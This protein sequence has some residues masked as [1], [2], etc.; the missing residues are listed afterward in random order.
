MRDDPLRIGAGQLFWLL[1]KNAPVR[2]LR[3]LQEI[4]TELRVLAVHDCGVEVHSHLAV[5][6]LSRCGFSIFPDRQLNLAPISGPQYCFPPW[7]QKCPACSSSVSLPRLFRRDGRLWPFA[8]SPSWVLLLVS[9]VQTLAPAAQIS[10][11]FQETL[12]KVRATRK[13][14]RD[15]SIWYSDTFVLP[16]PPAYCFVLLSLPLSSLGL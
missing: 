11:S 7:T 6:L 3:V 2:Y 4:S 12:Q 5:R 15:L 8:P 16:R 14:T 10:T 1:G 9:V 13:L